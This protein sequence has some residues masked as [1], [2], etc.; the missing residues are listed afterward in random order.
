MT[1]IDQWRFGTA[2]RH[3][4]AVVKYW[5][6]PARSTRLSLKPIVIAGRQ[7]CDDGH[8]P[9]CWRTVLLPP[10][11]D[12]T[13]PGSSAERDLLAQA[14]V[15]RNSVI[16]REKPSNSCWH[17]RGYELQRGDESGGYLRPDLSEAT[18]GELHGPLDHGLKFVAQSIQPKQAL[19]Q[20]CVAIGLDADGD[21]I[22]LIHDRVIQVDPEASAT[23]HLAGL[24][25]AV[26]VSDMGRGFD[27]YRSWGH[28]LNASYPYLRERGDLDSLMPLLDATVL[29]QSPRETA[30]DDVAGDLA[31]ILRDLHQPVRE[32]AV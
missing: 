27:L 29:L 18:K 9:D 23:D 22:D 14:I 28:A 7:C 32:E 8:P 3:P 13:E 2:T 31:G 15:L 24:I 5:G 26:L 19:L 16:M 30:Q 11:V 17:L 12:Q 21:D 1:M 10:G 25:L 4:A 20:T 6:N